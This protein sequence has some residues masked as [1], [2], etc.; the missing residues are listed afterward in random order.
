MSYVKFTF[1]TSSS[2]RSEGFGEF[3]R[4]FGSRGLPA[5]AFCSD[6]TT[7][8]LDVQNIARQQPHLDHVAIYRITEYEAF[9]MKDVPPYADETSLT[10]AEI[11]KKYFNELVRR[12]PPELDHTFVWMEVMNE[13]RKEVHEADWV[14]EILYELGL[15]MLAAGRRLCGPAFSSGAPDEG[16][17]ETPG[18]LKYLRLCAANPQQ[19]AVSV[20]EYSYVTDTLMRG[21]G[22][23]VGRFTDI[24]DACRKHG[25][26]HD[27]LKIFITEFGWAERDVPKPDVAMTHLFEAGALYAQYPQVKMAAIWALDKGWSSLDEQVHKLMEP[28]KNLIKSSSPIPDDGQEEKPKK[29]KRVVNLLPQDATPEE[30]VAVLAHT[31]E[32]RETLMQSADDAGYLVAA[33]DPAT[34]FVRAWDPKRWGATPTIEDWLLA[35]YG[36]KT[37]SAAFAD[38][39]DPPNPKPDPDPTFKKP[40][41]RDEMVGYVVDISKWQSRYDSKIGGYVADTINFDE[42]FANGVLGVIMRSSYGTSAD[43]TYGDWLSQLKAYKKPLG[44]YHFLSAGVDPVAQARKF[45][46][47][48][49]LDGTLGNWLDVE[50]LSGKLPTREDVYSF[51]EEF[52]RLAPDAHIGIYTNPASLVQLRL[53]EWLADLDLWIAHY[54]S[55]N[56]KLR[57]PSIKAPWAANGFLFWQFGTGRIGGYARDIDLNLVNMTPEEWEYRFGT[58]AETA[59]VQPPQPPP[60]APAGDARIGLHASADGYVDS[61]EF[62]Q[63]RILKPG[64]IKVMSSTE[65]RHV[66][67]LGQE[68]A[69]ATFIVRA[70][71][72]FRGKTYP[73]SAQE[74]V[75]STLSDVKRTID[76]L[77]A[78]SEILVELH[79]EPN[80]R[81]EG[82]EV[83][84]RDGRAFGEWLGAVSR[85][86]QEALASRKVKL[87]YPGLSPGPAFDGRIE[88]KRFFADSVAAGA[89][90]HLSAVGV[91]AYWSEPWPMAQALA[92]VDWHKTACPNWDVWITESCNNGKLPISKASQKAREMVQ[93]WQEMKKR[94]FVRGVTFYVASARDKSWSWET[95]SCETWVPVNMAKLVKAEM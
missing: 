16:A 89:L 87:M 4:A 58:S 92:W 50:P 13:T 59:P 26:P 65:P 21:N 74:F 49:N 67:Q 44:A 9:G 60:P 70:F 24:L 88:A 12:W 2:S 38:L 23:L 81:Q 20:H 5:L 76:H 94:P 91:H 40:T 75:N 31:H 86:Y 53:D 51:L 42:L 47:V 43:P 90:T 55:P 85:M 32:G 83:S 27:K 35:N 3:L 71:L 78:Q 61:A 56:S 15:L 68:H 34:S 33:G 17:W 64:V 48:A 66:A 62:E 36:V 69:G 19:C 39:T 46:E 73:V 8:L 10:P 82:A 30:K 80:L 54:D 45:V 11:A 41:S 6:G 72:D 95:G 18:M 77:P 29:I 57:A 14:G 25:I 84:W 52:R 1:H 79:N 28:L 37:I 7:G 93:F 22:R 63:F